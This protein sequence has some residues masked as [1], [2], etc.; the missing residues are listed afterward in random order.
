M[1]RGLARDAFSVAWQLVVSVLV[2]GIVFIGL[3]PYYSGIQCVDRVDGRSGCDLY[4]LT[5]VVGF[6]WPLSSS[7]ETW[8]SWVSGITAL[9]VGS[10]L[11]ATLRKRRG[12][13]DPPI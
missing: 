7:G 3:A 9:S 4:L 11:L 10:A 8:P 5:S 1:D 6:P 2:V 12:E 13:H